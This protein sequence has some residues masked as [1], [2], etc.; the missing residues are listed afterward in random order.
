[1][2]RAGSATA[3]LG[4]GE[5][6]GL[7]CL[8]ATGAAAG[9][10]RRPPLRQHTP[11]HCLHHR[12]FFLFLSPS[13]TRQL[14][15]FQGGVD[16]K[17]SPA[18]EATPLPPEQMRP[19][20]PITLA[21]AAAPA[22]VHRRGHAGC[23]LLA[24]SH[25][26]RRWHSATPLPTPVCCLPADLAPACRHL[27][28]THWQACGTA[29]CGWPTAWAG[30]SWS[31][32]ATPACACA[33]WQRAARSRPRAPLLSEVRAHHSSRRIACSLRRPAAASA[34]QPPVPCCGPRRGLTA[35]PVLPARF[36]V[37]SSA[38]PPLQAWPPAPT[39]RWRPALLPSSRHP[40]HEP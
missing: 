7:V 11:H 15:S 1:M 14:A 33:A 26:A 20:G 31:A 2:R 19:P 35:R 17:T 9:P 38:L 39:T 6:A 34:L 37:N 23:R 25:A 16:S 32:C 36:C 22:L 4:G 13:P 27:R 40:N 5:E 12:I 30:P 24:D 29:T 21:G 3:V 10:R 28:H 8:T 18:A